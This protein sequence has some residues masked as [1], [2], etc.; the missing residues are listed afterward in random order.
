MIK[1]CSSETV[2]ERRAYTS[3]G[4]SRMWSH[5]MAAA[6]WAAAIMCLLV[7]RALSGEG[8]QQQSKLIIAVVNMD[9]LLR[10]YVAYQEANRKFEAEVKWRQERLTIRE[11]LKSDERR[12]LDNLEALER[13][14]KLTEKDKKRLEELK[15]ISEERRNTLLKL[16]MT[17]KLTDEERR[18]LEELQEVRRSGEDELQRLQSVYEAE[19]DK[20]QKLY[21][22]RFAREISE[23]IKTVAQRYGIKLVVA[24]RSDEGSQLLLDEIVLYADPTLEITQ[25]V[26]TIL[27]TKQP[28]SPETKEQPKK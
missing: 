13:E 3:L 2:H 22:D 8:G 21:L 16:T 5:T 4:M 7:D 25:E 24:R 9:K 11:M 27:N 10:D 19:L 28:Q 26:L 15:R 6:I 23:A 14:G 18:Q 12:E 17:K 20:L 1:R